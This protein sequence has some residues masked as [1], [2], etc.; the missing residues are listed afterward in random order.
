MLTARTNRFAGWHR[1]SHLAYSNESFTEA[2]IP[3]RFFGRFG[4]LWRSPRI[5]MAEVTM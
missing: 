5:T 3:E 1:R 4:F 2:L